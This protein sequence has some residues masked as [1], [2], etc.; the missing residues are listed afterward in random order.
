MVATRMLTHSNR[1]HTSVA[2]STLSPF[3]MSRM[4]V[5]LALLS[6]L[7]SAVVAQQPSQLAHPQSP[8]LT[9][10]VPWKFLTATTLSNLSP[11]QFAGATAANADIPGGNIKWDQQRRCRSNAECSFMRVMMCGRHSMLR[12]HGGPVRCRLL[13]EHRSDQ[14]IVQ[15]VEARLAIETRRD[16]SLRQVRLQ[17]SAHA[18]PHT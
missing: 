14:H 13:S 1:I 2:R 7:L 8:L 18:S 15:W 12:L 3:A 16:S 6:L 11:A 5:A 9:D 4:L 17:Q 10:E